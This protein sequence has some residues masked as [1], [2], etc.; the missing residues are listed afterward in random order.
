MKD[1]PDKP[2]ILLLTIQYLPDF[3]GAAVR[4]RN[5]ARM[6]AKCGFKVVVLTSQPQYLY[7][8][9]ISRK[10][11][12]KLLVREHEDTNLIVYRFK[13]PPVPHNNIV[14]R[15]IR[16][17]SYTLISLALVPYILKREG[18]P[19][20]VYAHFPPIFSYMVGYLISLL[21][22][23]IILMYDIHDLLPEQM[24]TLVQNNIQLVT[25]ILRTLA[26]YLYNKPK[27]IT[28]CSITM[29][30]YLKRQY[31]IMQPTIYI[32]TGIEK[33]KVSLNKEKGREL[34]IKSNIYHPDFKNK[35][36]FLYAGVMDPPQN[37]Q[38]IIKAF[39]RIR[40]KDIILLMFGEGKIK[41]KLIQLAKNTDNVYIYDSVPRKIL[42]II[43]TSIDVGIVPLQV[44]KFLK[45]NVPTKLFDYIRFSKPVLCITNSIEM[46]HIIKKYKIGVLADGGV[47]EIYEALMKAYNIV[48]D[49]HQLSMYEN[50][51]NKYK[52]YIDIDNLSI[53]ICK[54]LIKY[55]KMV[56]KH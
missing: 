51:I 50:N 12:G 4:T 34:L 29:L 44:S 33:P 25:S 42:D 5:I 10:Y 28:G 14:N 3:G 46:R 26:T 47:D 41:D 21:N 32:P 13:L 37:L 20:I 52:K 6:L 49:R 36:I 23:N 38:N 8:R 39:K 45:F 11:Q 15:F 30:E 54:Y 53:N 1:S 31:S 17:L 18:K 24:E 22:R 43:I 16:Y 55:I 56:N 27:I 2:I 9:P 7:G 40:R 35:V 19:N 48:K